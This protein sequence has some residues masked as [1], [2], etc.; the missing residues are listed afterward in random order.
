MDADAQEDDDNMKD[1]KIEFTWEPNLRTLAVAEDGREFLNLINAAMEWLEEQPWW[2][3]I[4]IKRD[5]L[6]RR[7][8]RALWEYMGRTD[9]VPKQ[10]KIFINSEDLKRIYPG[11]DLEGDIDDPKPS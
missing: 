4:M 6:N 8:C 10:L 7:E 11:I 5:T 9:K 3:G 2:K 1:Y